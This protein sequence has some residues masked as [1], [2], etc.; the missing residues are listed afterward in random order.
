MNGTLQML[1]RLIPSPLAHA[2]H[3]PVDASHPLHYLTTPE[4]LMGSIAIIACIVFTTWFIGRLIY[5]I[6]K[7]T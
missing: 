7:P 1:T 4:H 5:R 2:G 6:S 3:G